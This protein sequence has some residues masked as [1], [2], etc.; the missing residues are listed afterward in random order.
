LPGPSCA[1]DTTAVATS[2]SRSTTSRLRARKSSSEAN[3]KLAKPFTLK[4]SVEWEE[5]LARI[6][7]QEEK[8]KR[9]RA[10]VAAVL[11]KRSYALI[12]WGF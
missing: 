5:R 6:A 11:G 4:G 1:T 2:A 9:R 8:E 10:R 7:A 3:H 12:L